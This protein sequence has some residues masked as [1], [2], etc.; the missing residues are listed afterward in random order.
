M[1][2]IVLATNNQGKVIEFSEKLKDSGITFIPQSEFNVPDADETGKTYIEN[3]IIKARQACEITG[4]PAIGDDSGLEIDALDGAPGIYSQ[5][6]SGEDATPTKNIQKLLN[7]LKDVP[8]EK[9]TGRCKTILAFLKHADDPSPVICEGVW[10]ISILKQ[11]QGE[12]GFG[13]DPVLFVKDYNCSAAELDTKVKNKISH[14]G[15]ALEKF[16]NILKTL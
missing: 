8:D 10:E 12:W 15:L 16:K 7:A 9:R 1:K 11:P 14:R 6:Y 3:A 5:R 2:K 13:Y 4:Y